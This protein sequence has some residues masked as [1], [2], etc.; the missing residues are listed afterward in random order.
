MGCIMRK[1]TLARA[2]LTI[3]SP[4]LQTQLQAVPVLSSL[5]ISIISFSSFTFPG[6]P[7]RIFL[8]FLPWLP[9]F[10]PFTDEI[11]HIQ[12]A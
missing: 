3:G 6:A 12:D 11:S 10:P 7:Y 1:L 4:H 9:C 8:Q 2:N 5:Y